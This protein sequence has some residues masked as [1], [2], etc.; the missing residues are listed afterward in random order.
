MGAIH[1]S[2]NKLHIFIVN[3]Q[4]KMTL[5]L[6]L[7]SGHSPSILSCF[8][9]LER[10]IFFSSFIKTLIRLFKVYI[11]RECY[12][13]HLY[14]RLNP[15]LCGNWNTCQTRLSFVFGINYHLLM[16]FTAFQILTFV[17]ILCY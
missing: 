17:L 5:P 15:L 4:I 7:V 10:K 12:I 1:N 16:S 9:R 8:Y 13:F 6:L 3:G 2:R 14:N 11:Y